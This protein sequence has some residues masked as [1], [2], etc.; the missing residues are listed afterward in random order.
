LRP[1]P[2]CRPRG[3]HPHLLYSSTPPFFEDVFVTHRGCASYR[4]PSGL[5]PDPEWRQRSSLVK[6]PW[7][8]DGEPI[9]PGGDPL[10]MDRPSTGRGHRLLAPGGRSEEVTHLVMGPAQ[11][12]G[13]ASGTPGQPSEPPISGV[14]LCDGGGHRAGLAVATVRRFFRPATRNPHDVF[15]HVKLGTIDSMRERWPI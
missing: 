6:T 8:G 2:D 10:D 4:V 5:A 7:S 15:L 1:A 13:A 9:A 12:G 14:P 3:A 11:A